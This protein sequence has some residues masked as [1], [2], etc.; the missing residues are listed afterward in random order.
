MAEARRVAGEE[1][2]GL[3]AAAVAARRRRTAIW[4]W[5]QQ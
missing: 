3:V 1:K 5:Q 2:E 4:R